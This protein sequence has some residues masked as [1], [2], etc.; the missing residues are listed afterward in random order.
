MATWHSISQRQT[1]PLTGYAIL[2]NKKREHGMT[3][4]PLH[5]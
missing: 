5:W 4:N 1:N 2:K 3:A